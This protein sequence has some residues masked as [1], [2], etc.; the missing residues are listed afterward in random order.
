MTTKMQ[1][2]QD[3][4]GCAV[5]VGGRVRII[6]LTERFLQSLPSD[7]QAAVRSMVGCV[8]QVEEIDEYGHAW[9]TKWWTR[10]EGHAE[11]HGIALSPSE[12]EVVP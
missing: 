12:M 7:E 4:V 1:E 6:A 9:V 2:T 11:S 5:R 10:A 3:F 8:F